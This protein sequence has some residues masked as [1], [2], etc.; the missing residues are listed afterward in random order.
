[1]LRVT[2]GIRR[3]RFSDDGIGTGRQFP[4]PFYLAAVQD[5]LPSGHIEEFSEMVRTLNL[6]ADIPANR[7][8]HITLPADVPAGN[9]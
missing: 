6:T 2:D 3:C 8:Q 4:K 1:M 5:L 9:E 7:E